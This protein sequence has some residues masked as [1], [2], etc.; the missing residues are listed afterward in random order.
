MRRSRKVW[1]YSAWANE[2][3][4][5]VRRDSVN[6]WLKGCALPS[7]KQM[8]GVM[9]RRLL[10]NAQHWASSPGKLRHVPKSLEITSGQ[11]GA[12]TSAQGSWA[13]SLSLR[14]TAY[15][16]VLGVRRVVGASDRPGLRKS[17]RGLSA[18]LC[19][20]SSVKVI[21]AQSLT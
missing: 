3:S 12:F 9:C 19:S 7:G 6:R 21:R 20:F 5:I 11:E 17:E 16:L 1:G 2:Y 8:M 4:R 10:R 13:T 15:Y 14:I 18:S